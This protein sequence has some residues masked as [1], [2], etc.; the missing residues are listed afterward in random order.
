MDLLFWL[1]AGGVTAVALALSG[2]EALRLYVLL[3]CGCGAVLYLLGVSRVLGAL[4][5]AIAEAYHRTEE[6]PARKA[7]QQRQQQKREERSH[8]MKRKLNL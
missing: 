3:G 5:R 2:E 8:N 7:R 1:G 6:S 4:G